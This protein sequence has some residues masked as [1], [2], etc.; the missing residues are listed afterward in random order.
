MHCTRRWRSF[1]CAIHK[2]DSTL[3]EVKARGGALDH[4]ESRHPPT[5]RYSPDASGA[6]IINRMAPPAAALIDAGAL[7]VD[8]DNAAGGVP[9]GADGQQTVTT[10]GRKDEICP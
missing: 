1:I 3:G 4:R 2:Y 7:M 9:L 6:D 10:S 5:V 8:L